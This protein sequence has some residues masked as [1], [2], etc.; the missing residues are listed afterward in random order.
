[1]DSDLLL[2]VN[3]LEQIQGG[4]V[5]ANKGQILA[6]L[7]L[8]IAGLVSDRPLSELKEKLDILEEHASKLGNKITSPFMT[9]SFLGL[10]VIPELRVT[11]LGL[12]DVI[13]AQVVDL[14]VK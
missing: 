1:N 11:D 9:L 3:R 14:E 8:E 4:F 13:K 2:A 10:E 5:I 12:V 7:Q 6:E